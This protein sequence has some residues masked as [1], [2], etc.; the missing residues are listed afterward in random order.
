M[1]GSTIKIISVLYLQS[2]RTFTVGMRILGIVVQLLAVVGNSFK[3]GVLPVLVKTVHCSKKCT[4]FT[5]D[6]YICIHTYT[7]TIKWLKTAVKH[8]SFRRWKLECTLVLL[9]SCCF[10]FISLLTID[11][12]QSCCRSTEWWLKCL[13]RFSVNPIAADSNLNT[14][15]VK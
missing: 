7:K 15:V 8:Y 12:F 14:N 9:F 5:D 13:R 10:V 4:R 3:A 6:Y 11:I 2:H 1:H